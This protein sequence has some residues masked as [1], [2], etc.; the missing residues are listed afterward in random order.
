MTVVSLCLYPVV[1]RLAPKFGKKRIII[2]GFFAY[3]AV[4][5]ITSICG[6]GLWWGYLIAVLAG[7]PMAIL[8]IL[9]QAVVADIA[10]AD[11]RTY[12]EQRSGM[13]F[14]A[15]TFA[16]KLGQALS[17]LIFTSVT[18]IDSPFRY[19]MTAI[20]ATVCCIAGAVLF[21]FYNEKSVMDIIAAPA[22][23]PA[24]GHDAEE[25]P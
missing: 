1:N 7:V 3:A 15:R 17:L 13:F 22:A 6:E 25:T 11:A 21:F 20:I 19:R 2:V 16:M 14:A 23:T 12:G 18:V 10:E 4:F 24:P 5:L 8:G 9:P